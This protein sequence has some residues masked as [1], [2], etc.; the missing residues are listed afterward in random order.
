MVRLADLPVVE[1]AAY[2]AIPCEA[3]ET[4]PWVE[5]SPNGGWRW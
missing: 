2:R 3:F 5:G 1:A 4:T